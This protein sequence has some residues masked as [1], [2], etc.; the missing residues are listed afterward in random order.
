MSLLDL[1]ISG[2]PYC[3][4]GLNK[5]KK[6]YFQTSSRKRPL[7][8]QN[9]NVIFKFQNKQSFGILKLSQFFYILKPKNLQACLAKESLEGILCF[10]FSG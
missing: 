8:V 7:D 3:T 9:L 4:L 2:L 1:E 10:V 6:C 5:V